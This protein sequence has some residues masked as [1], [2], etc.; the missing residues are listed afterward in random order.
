[1]RSHLL[2]AAEHKIARGDALR[3]RLYVPEVFSVEERDAINASRLAQ[4]QHAVAAPGRPQQLILLI[5]EV[6]EIVPGRYGYK[7]RIKHVPDQALAIDEP[8]YRWLGRLFDAALALWGSADCVHMVTI[9]T[10]GVS[11]AGIPAITQMS[12]MPVTPQWLPASDSFERQLVERLVAHGRSF[13]KSLRYNLRRDQCLATATLTDMG[14][15]GPLLFIVPPR[16][17]GAAPECLHDVI[18]GCESPAWT[19]RPASEGMPRL[20]APINYA[21]I[22]AP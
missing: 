19:W 20:P 16:L 7:A 14:S 6:K 17:D 10:F 5:G 22:G 13:I 2:R 15:P 4:W 18:A 21:S 1:M 3:G 9:A 11:T 12:L 8:L